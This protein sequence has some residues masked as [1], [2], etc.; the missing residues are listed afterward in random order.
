MPTRFSYIG[1]VLLNYRKLYK[2]ALLL[3][4]KIQQK[5]LSKHTKKTKASLE[6][7]YNHFY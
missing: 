3:L 5:F 1:G 7:H 4:K 6:Y 2:Y